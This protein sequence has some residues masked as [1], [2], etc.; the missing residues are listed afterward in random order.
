MGLADRL[1]VACGAPV[2]VPA[3]G[4]WR[5]VVRDRMPAL[6]RCGCPGNAEAWGG[7]DMEWQDPLGSVVRWKNRAGMRQVWKWVGCVVVWLFLAGIPC[8]I[9][10]PG[11]GPPLLLNWGE[12][13]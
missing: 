13:R 10:S 3:V 9:S 2:G 12:R 1:S 6:L 11:L 5:C 8:V 4:D 7:L